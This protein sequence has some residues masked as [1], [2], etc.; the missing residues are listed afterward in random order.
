MKHF[1]L[2][3]LVLFTVS[4]SA[5]GPQPSLS[6]SEM[7]TTYETSLLSA[8]PLSLLDESKD[9]EHSLKTQTDVSATLLSASNKLQGNLSYASTNYTQDDEEQSHLTFDLHLQDNDNPIP[10]FMSG[11]LDTLYL[12]QTF[13][14]TIQDFLLSI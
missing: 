12:D 7:E 14:F 5:C 10:I 8:L 4:L 13:Y 2:F 1:Y 3:L 9:E 6:L 11:T